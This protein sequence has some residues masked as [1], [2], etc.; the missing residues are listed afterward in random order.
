MKGLPLQQYAECL[1]DESR[2]LEERSG[3]QGVVYRQTGREGSF[4]WEVFYGTAGEK[5]VR[6]C[7]KQDKRRCGLPGRAK[8]RSAVRHDAAERAA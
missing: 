3:D 6:F 2:C 4:A 8:T 5:I 7:W 1:G